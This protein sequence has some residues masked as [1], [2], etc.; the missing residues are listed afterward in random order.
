[1][2]SGPPYPHSRE[3]G[4]DLGLPVVYHPKETGIRTCRLVRVE[5]VDDIGIR[6]QGGTQGRARKES[7]M[8]QLGI[9]LN[10]QQQVSIIAPWRM[11]SC[12]IGHFMP[13]C[14]CWQELGS[15]GDISSNVWMTDRQARILSSLEFITTLWTFWTLHMKIRK[16]YSSHCNSLKKF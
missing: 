2:T 15:S 10:S 11:V 5:R 3:Q 9:G 13:S 8:S 7:L 1:V 4:P 14:C 12:C 16:I 6:T